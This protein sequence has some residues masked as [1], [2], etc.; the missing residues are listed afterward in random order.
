MEAQWQP[1]VAPP[2]QHDGPGFARGDYVLASQQRQTQ[3]IW[4]VFRGDGH[5]TLEQLAGELL[6]D[7]NAGEAVSFPREWAETI[8]HTA[9]HH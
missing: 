1:N 9:S 4:H 7:W 8:I 3:L 6:Q 5:G 2:P